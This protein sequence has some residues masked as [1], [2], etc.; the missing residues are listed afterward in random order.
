MFSTTDKTDTPHDMPKCSRVPKAPHTTVLRNVKTGSFIKETY[1]ASDNQWKESGTYHKFL[2]FRAGPPSAAGPN[3]ST[4]SNLATSKPFSYNGHVYQSAESA[5]MAQRVHTDSKHRFSIK[6]D[7]G[8][9]KNMRLTPATNAWW[10]SLAL[11][12]QTR[13]DGSVKD[14]FWHANRM[15]GQ[16]AKQATKA[17][18]CRT[19]GLRM[20]QKPRPSKT[21]EWDMWRDILTSKYTAD[22]SAKAT[23]LATEGCLLVETA[24]GLGHTNTQETSKWGGLVTKEGV[25][26]GENTAGRYLC[27][28]RTML[29]RSQEQETLELA[30]S[31]WT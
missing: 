6:G 24:K 16:I 12:R 27:R 29:L 17:D 10:N 25:L 18:A 23:L 1:S 26:L 21:E 30:L 8:S 9:F 28:V 14:N 3:V 7:L 20:S 15:S 2:Y 22:A 11:N 19:L 5:Y 4:L 13:K 31:L